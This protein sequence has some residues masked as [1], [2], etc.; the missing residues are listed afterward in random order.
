M[1]CLPEDKALGVKWDTEKDTLGF[2]MKLVG[3]PSTR[4]GLLSMLTSAYDPLGL[5][6]PFML[7]GKQVIQQLC[8]EK[9]QW[10]K[11]IDERLGQHMS[12][13]SGKTIC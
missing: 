5:G 8:Q 6:A 11:Q 12:G 1:G 13:L 3:K 2:T 4:H 7:K 10:N 9:L